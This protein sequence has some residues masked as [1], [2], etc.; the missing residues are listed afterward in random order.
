MMN[1]RDICL[2]FVYWLSDFKSADIGASISVSF[3]KGS[4]Y[5]SIFHSASAK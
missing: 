5:T 1:A 2:W 4:N 3:K